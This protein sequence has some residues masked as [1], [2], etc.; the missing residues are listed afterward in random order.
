MVAVLALGIGLGLSIYYFKVIRE[1]EIPVVPIQPSKQ[2]DMG[3]ENTHG[4]AKNSEKAGQ[5]LQEL[6]SKS[7]VESPNLEN[8]VNNESRSSEIQVLSPL[9]G[10]SVGQTILFEWQG[11]NKGPY[12]LKVLTNMEKVLISRSLNEH[13]L[14]L[15]LQLSPGLYYWKLESNGELLYIGKF[16]VK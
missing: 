5:P 15:A 1:G 10:A 4:G 13:R 2:I 3:I 7:F 6:H 8:L 16:F 11:E 12:G 14:D 9:N